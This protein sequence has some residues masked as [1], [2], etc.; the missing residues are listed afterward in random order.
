MLCRDVCA[1]VVRLVCVRSLIALFVAIV[2]RMVGVRSLLALF[3]AIADRIV[4]CVMCMCDVCVCV[5]RM[6]VCECVWSKF[7]LCLMGCAFVGNAG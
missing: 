3:V 4:I 7:V 6:Y 5:V 1:F 2:D